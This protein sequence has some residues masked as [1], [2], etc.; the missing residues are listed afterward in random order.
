MR[1]TR[2][3]WMWTAFFAFVNS[4]ALG[5]VV[6]TDDSFTSSATPKANYGSS[7]AEVVGSGSNTYLKF[8][9]VGLPS[10][11]N[12]SNIANAN[13]VIYV[14]AVVSAGT[15]DVYAV[16]G[17][18][19]EGTITYNSA[20]ALGS[21][22][23]SAVPVKKAGYVSLNMTSTVQAWLNGTLANNG[24]A[25]VPSAGSSILASIDSKENILTSHAAQLNL[26]LVSGGP[27]GPQ[28]PQGPA[29]PPGPAGAPGAAGASGAPGAQGPQGSPGQ[30]FNFR[31][32]FSAS[33]AYAAYDVV[34][35][36]GSTYVA[37]TATNPGD[38]T[39]DTNAGWTLMAPQGAP[40]PMGATGPA[41]P[42]GPPGQVTESD[43]LALVARVAV[44]ESAQGVTP[45]PPPPLPPPIQEAGRLDI[46]LGGSPQ[47]L[48]FDGAN[49]WVANFGG[50]VTELRASDATTLGT[51]PVLGAPVQIIYAA[52]KIWVASW[53]DAT[54]DIP[55]NITELSLSG[56]VLNI[57][58][59]GTDPNSGQPLEPI[60]LASDGTNVYF[61]VANNSTYRAL[62]NGATVT[63]G[64][65]RSI[66][67]YL[68]YDGTQIWVSYG[69]TNTVSAGSPMLPVTQVFTVGQLPVALAFD[70]VNIWAANY[71]DGTVTK[72]RD[73][74][75]AKLGTFAAGST[76]SGIAFDGANI[77]VTNNSANTV[78]LLRASD[79][80][81]VATYNTA[82][83]PLGIVFD[84][85]HMWVGTASGIVSKF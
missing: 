12:G 9:F 42:M 34:T 62:E 80:G 40:G 7:I 27:Q 33:T 17:A 60:A 32:P 53:G 76:P 44:L 35:F 20:P 79:G 10:G 39:P 26:V 22:I 65:T 78:T 64:N 15:M 43:F 57:V 48:A 66:A 59:L 74:D 30:G 16:N 63:I 3:I 37:K 85:N 38:P 84:G 29:G 13:V 55:G 24:I 6:L 56:Q 50:S 18:W 36:N 23:L 1:V 31:G 47:A 11:L 77:W 49:V 8:S 69:G 72:L 54:E 25:L 71:T 75:G 46:S 41:G 61:T 2:S 67:D 73:S 83:S 5:Q 58:N 19:S 14:D 4:L 70:S 68:L 52:Q 82:S 21:P 28:G 81:G 51:F 45:P